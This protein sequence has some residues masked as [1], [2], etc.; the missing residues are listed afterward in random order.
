MSAAREIVVGATRQ[1]GETLSRAQLTTGAEVR[2]FVAQRLAEA[3]AAL[4]RVGLAA[5][6]AELCNAALQRLAEL[7]YERDYD[8]SQPNMSAT[9]RIE[10]P[11]PMGKAGYQRFGLRR[12]ESDV[13]RACLL[14]RVSRTDTAPVFVYN[15]DDRRWYVNLSA[16]PGEQAAQQALRNFPIGAREYRRQHDRLKGERTAPTR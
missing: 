13:L 11:A 1:A 10:I 9:G 6:A 16:Y 5:A 15:D 14:A 3:T 4:S 8:G 12:L 2:P 7:C